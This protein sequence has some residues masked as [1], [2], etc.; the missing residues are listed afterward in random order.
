[1]P[2]TDGRVQS[3]VGNLVT[4]EG[5]AAAVDGV[6]VVVH[7]ASDPGASGPTDVEGTERLVDRRVA[8]NFLKIGIQYLHVNSVKCMH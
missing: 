1:M 4:G 2:A 7:A 3:V 5:L 8:A 6:D